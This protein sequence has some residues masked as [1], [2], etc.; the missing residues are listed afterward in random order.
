MSALLPLNPGDATVLVFA[1]VAL[2]DHGI[3]P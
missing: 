3:R 1:L 2:A